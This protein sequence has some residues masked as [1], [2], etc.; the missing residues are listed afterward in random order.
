MTAGG[1]LIT[2]SCCRNKYIGGF[3]TLFVA[4]KGFSIGFDIAL[5]L[6]GS[7]GFRLGSS[8]SLGSIA[9]EDILSI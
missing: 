7:V 8:L 6:D 5:K 1:G 9:R 2:L 4:V 3:I